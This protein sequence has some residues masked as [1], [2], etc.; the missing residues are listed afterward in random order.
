MENLNNIH[1]RAWVQ[2]KRTI[3]LKTWKIL[4]LHLEGLVFPAQPA[5]ESV[6]VMLKRRLLKE[7]PLRDTM[8]STVKK[9][10]ARSS[11][12]GISYIFE[13]GMSVLGRIL[14][15]IIVTVVFAFGI[16]MYVKLCFKTPHCSFEVKLFLV[17]MGE[18]RGWIGVWW[19]LMMIFLLLIR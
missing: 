19:G 5:A 8:N 11:I 10:A 3:V 2:S 14:W 17:I 4:E 16:Y 15:C 12:Q 1:P 6:A 18:S 13:D 7:Q 9:Y